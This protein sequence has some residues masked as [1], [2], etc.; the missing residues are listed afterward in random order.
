[1]SVVIP[2]YNE[3]ERMN[4]MLEEA[5]VFLDAEYGR[6]PGKSKTKSN[7]SLGS[8]AGKRVGGYE[9]LI[10]NDGSKDKTV[11]VALAFSRKYALHDIL[12]ICTLKEN[13]G[14]GG[15]VTHGFRHVRGEYTVFADADGASKFEDLAKLVQGCDEV[16]DEPKRGIAV[17]S[18]A[19]MVGSEAVIKVFHSSSSTKYC[20]RKLTRAALRN[21]QRL[22]ALLPSPPTPS[23]PTGNIS[24]SGHPMR[25]QTLLTRLSTSYHTLHAR[26]RLDL[27]RRDADVSRERTF[28]NRVWA[29]R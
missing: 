18:R 2:A 23:H 14:K 9:I 7:G 20:T 16:A 13:R 15:A 4:I 27:R 3:E 11:E 6:V 29:G 24:D 5:V 25:F 1:M 26:R 12:R 19:H 8:K 10:V 22:N 21:P 28:R 17:G